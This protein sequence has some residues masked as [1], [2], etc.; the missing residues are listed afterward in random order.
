[1]NTYVR[2]G[3][4]NETKILQL[5]IDTVSLKT[6]YSRVWNGKPLQK[7]IEIEFNVRFHRFIGRIIQKQKFAISLRYFGNYSISNTAS[8]W[9]HIFGIRNSHTNTHATVASITAFVSMW[10]HT[11]DRHSSG[12][13]FGVMIFEFDCKI[14]QVIS[15]QNGH[16]F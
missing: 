7:S 11:V 5:I 13:V 9:F 15:C 14:G 3:E 12:F 1:M 4:S 6:M 16:T 8:H 10:K 2:T